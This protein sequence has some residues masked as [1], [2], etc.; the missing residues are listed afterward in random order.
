MLTKPWH[1]S[2]SDILIKLAPALPLLKEGAH[3][4]S[5]FIKNRFLCLMKVDSRILKEI[6]KS[7]S[8][9]HTEIGS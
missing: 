2:G 9:G 5:S 6:L 7:K 4:K 3:F 8:K 1:P